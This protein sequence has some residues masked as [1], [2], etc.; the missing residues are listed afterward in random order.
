MTASAPSESFGLEPA[1]L[2][3]FDT[4]L[5]AWVDIATTPTTSPSTN[6]NTA[7]DPVPT[8]TELTFAHWNVL[9]HMWGCSREEEAKRWQTC[10]DDIYR[11]SDP[12][13]GRKY[14]TFVSLTE[15]TEDFMTVLNA[16]EWVRERYYV[17]SP[18]CTEGRKHFTILLCLKA[19]GVPSSVHQFRLHRLARERC[20]YAVYDSGVVPCVD[21][22]T[23]VGV[24]AA[25]LTARA[26]NHEIR[27]LQMSQLQELTTP[28]EADDLHV[29][30]GDLNL[31]NEELENPF[32]GATSVNIEDG[33]RVYR[34]VYDVVG[35]PQH[36]AITWDACRNVTITR[37]LYFL[38]GVESREMRL[39]RVLVAG[40]GARGVGPV[41]PRESRD[42]DRLSEREGEGTK[43]G[44][45]ATTMGVF[46]NHLE[47]RY[48]SSLLGRMAS[49]MAYAT[50]VMT[51][52][53]RFDPD[54]PPSDH[55]GLYVE[56]FNQ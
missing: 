20:V 35:R 43:G 54:S 8:P 12:Q 45:W 2:Y 44:R 18:T 22:R 36:A 24:T 3:T 41:G 32:I 48:G 47:S 50:R 40:G 53:A 42:G 17:V 15:A 5:S 51:G 38:G 13:S 14:T 23:R 34:D 28:S 1:F 7:P 31:H 39:D 11:L 30:M 25:H 6:T 29:I 33:S 19:L 26:Y 56:I 4:E 21:S 16:T 37:M 55:Y 46:G 27:R 52:M 10:L 49:A 9:Y